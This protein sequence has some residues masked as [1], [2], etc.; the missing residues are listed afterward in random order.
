MEG[1]IKQI[2]TWILKQDSS[3]QYE[4]KEIKEKRSVDSNAYAWVL[5]G[6]IQD[7]IRIPKE[8]IYRELIKN[9]GSYEIV[10]VRDEAVEKFRKA[11]S[12][13]E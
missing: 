1:T 7:K 12:K 10:P 4:V 8:E 11:W 3:K 9:I 6:K 2:I 13:T 5:I